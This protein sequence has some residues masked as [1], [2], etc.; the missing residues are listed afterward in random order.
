[1]LV[2]HFIKYHNYPTELHLCRNLNSRFS[3]YLLENIS[4]TYEVVIELNDFCLYT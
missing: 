2:V 3:D 1:M 4:F